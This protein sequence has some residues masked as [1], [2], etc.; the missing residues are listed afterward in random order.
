M[1]VFGIKRLFALKPFSSIS[2]WLLR[3]FMT[4]PHGLLFQPCPKA[5]SKLIQLDRF[6][7]QNILFRSAWHGVPC[8]ASAVSAPPLTCSTGAGV[9]DEVH[10]SP[11]QNNCPA[12]GSG[13]RAGGQGPGP[14]GFMMRA[15][16][17]VADGKGVPGR[18][19]V[20]RWA[21]GS[22]H[23]WVFSLVV[24][25]G[26]TVFCRGDGGLEGFVLRCW[27][28]CRWT[29]GIKVGAVAKAHWADNRSK[30]AQ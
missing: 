9:P 11:S 30:M 3:C 15:L 19:A 5:L 13:P 18:T 4:P 27:W 23:R 17:C 20:G 1:Y 2:V 22:R 29:E 16:C 26:V 25:S 14:V 6:R 7:G 28:L 24:G 12:D 8:Q 21:W 10:L